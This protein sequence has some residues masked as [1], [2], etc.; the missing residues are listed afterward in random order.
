MRATTRSKP[1]HLEIDLDV[2]SE[3][4]PIVRTIVR[5]HL[6][7]WDLHGLT[8]PVALTV[9]ELLTNVLK[10]VPP[11]ARTGAR[12]ARLTVTR[13]P[14]ALNVCVRDFSRA[15]PVPSCAATDAEDGRGLQLVRAFADDFGWSPA[16]SGKD[17]WANF[18]IPS[19]DPNE[20]PRSRE[21][22]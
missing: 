15:L 20:G 21:A 8:A 7:L 22:S 1:G 2:T 6:K 19:V 9:S 17:V 10:H 14:G 13:L 4:V 16:N 12:S 3:A 18:T 5:A 11:D